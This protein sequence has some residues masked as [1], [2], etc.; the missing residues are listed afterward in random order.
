MIDQ[1]L[2]A[3]SQ[4]IG[5]LAILARL[6]ISTAESCTGGLLASCL[7]AA[8]GSSSYFEYGLISYSDQAKIT[9]LGIS[10]AILTKFSACSAQIVEAMASNCRQRSASHYSVA[11]S[12]IAGPNGGS[13]AN[14]VGTVYFGLASAA[15]TSSFML[16][17]PGNR[18]E[19]RYQACLRALQLIIDNIS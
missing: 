12:G 11:I 10:P 19:I 2:L 18:Q 15:R 8:S 13:V 4:Q 6:K 16:T 5:R 17:L 1:V 7:T 3:L 9:M 14:P